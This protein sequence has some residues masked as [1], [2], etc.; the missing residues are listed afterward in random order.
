[1]SP[2]HE[3]LLRLKAQWIAEWHA[4][5][6]PFIVRAALMFNVL[7]DKV[8]PAQYAAAVER[9]EWDTMPATNTIKTRTT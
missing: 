1:M 7:A 9:T 8:T 4:R 6:G 5:R 2:E 3:E